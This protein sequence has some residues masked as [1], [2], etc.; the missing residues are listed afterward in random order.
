MAKT[1]LRPE[2]TFEGL[3]SR[4]TRGRAPLTLAVA[5]AGLIGVALA[6]EVALAA[7]CALALAVAL[8]TFHRPQLGAPL[9]AILLPATVHADALGVQ[10]SPLDAAIGGCAV[11]YGVRLAARADERHM[12]P[13]H[14]AYVALVAC[15]G[16]S[17]LGP[18]D[19]SSQLRQLLFWGALGLVFHAVTSHLAVRRGAGLLL[20]GLAVAL[21]VE[22]ALALYEYAD[23]W[24]DRF[25]LR[26][27]AI[28]YP[29]P[30]GTLDHPNAL[31]QFL[32]L[33]AFI[34]LALAL[35]ERG[36]VR[37]LGFVAAAGAAVALPVTFSR[38]SWI[39]CA[40]GAAVFL[41]D[42]RARVPVLVGGA[43]V[44]ALGALL[45]LVVGGAIGERI[46]SLFAAGV[47]GLA[48]FRLALVERAAVALA[49]HPLTGVG[50]FEEMGVYAGRPDLVTHPH[51]LVL[52][53]AVFFGIPAALAFVAVVAL[54]FAAA[55]KRL[56]DR[57]GEAGAATG[58]LAF[59]VALVVN[60]LFEYPFW[61]PALTALIVLGLAV[62]Y[63]GTV[64]EQHDL[65]GET[66]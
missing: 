12:E 61:N 27:G 30:R 40:A 7:L 23:A 49:E 64:R 37:R 34:A 33:G 59:L 58:C 42:R 54:A 66:T 22:A 38:A 56:R 18:G 11:G 39:A 35:A 20:G 45:A 26:E 28:I 13:V 65:Q 31:A 50:R 24:S 43:V 44:C 4:A 9:V 17:L 8:A 46:S 6:G 36:A 2:P 19:T 1:V 62:A 53:V 29:L 25:S 60:G 57:V 21:L 15:I 51:N 5:G 14:W 47:S 16:L 52:G 41:I 63:A 48:N 32:V 10:A 3:W 55:S